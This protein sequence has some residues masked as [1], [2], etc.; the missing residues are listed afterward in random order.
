MIVDRTRLRRA[1]I[2]IL[3]GIGI[4][5]I[6]YYFSWAKL[7]FLA[8]LVLGILLS[9]LSTVYRIPIVCHLLDNCELKRAKKLP[10]KSALFFLAGSLLV[11]A[12]FQKEIALA[13]IAVLTFADPVSHFASHLSSK[14]KKRKTVLGF[15][16]SATVAIIVSSFLVPIRYSIPSSLITMF[17][18]TRFTFKL[19]QDYVDDNFLIPVTFAVLISIAKMIY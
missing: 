11:L 18:E 16:L 10:G 1:A 2:H 14:G 8:A 3:S 6:A 13:S 7:F 5:V 19:G 15:L 4:I 9:L 17:L 12:L